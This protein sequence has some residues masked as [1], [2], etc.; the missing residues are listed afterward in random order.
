MS[1][2][3]IWNDPQWRAYVTHVKTELVPMIDSSAMTVSLMPKDPADV[4]VK[5][6]VELGLSIML[7]KP[8]ILV[9][10]PGSRVPPKLE[11]IAEAV[12]EGSMDDP[13]A[14]SRLAAT[15]AELAREHE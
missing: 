14:R 6:A 3:D 8:I 5:F 15:L 4:D 1:G 12:I 10:D 2:D 7:E 9:I 11:A 13:D